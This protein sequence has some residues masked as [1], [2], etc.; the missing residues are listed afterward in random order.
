MRR[1]SSC[2][3]I[4]GVLTLGVAM[5]WTVS[6]PSAALAFLDKEIIEAAHAMANGTATA[7]QRAIAF[8]HNK[9]LNLM[10]MEGYPQMPQET[11]V[12]YQIEYQKMND[13]FIETAARRTNE[14]VVG[15]KPQPGKPEVPTPGTDTDKITTS[16]TPEKTKQFLNN[17]DEVVQEH[18][19][20]QGV[21]R[22]EGKTWAQVTDTDLMGDAWNSTPENFHKISGQQNNAYARPLAAQYE[23]VTRDV[24]TKDDVEAWKNNPQHAGKAPPFKEG[25]MKQPPTLAQHQAYAEEMKSK[26]DLMSN[27][28]AKTRQKME[29]LMKDNPGLREEYTN[30]RKAPDATKPMSDNLNRLTELDADH[31]KLNALESKY[32]KRFNDA[33]DTLAEQHGLSKPSQVS[34]LSAGGS[35]RMAVAEGDLYVDEKG[36][37]I[38]RQAVIE[39][40]GKFFD[41]K[42]NELT[43]KTPA[44]QQAELVEHRAQSHAV[45]AMDEHLTDQA[46]RRRAEVLGELAAKD[47]KVRAQALADIAEHTKDSSASLKG[48]IVENLR[49]ARKTEIVESLRQTLGEKFDPKTA[50]GI[51]QRKAD[52]FAQQAAEQMRTTATSANK[53]VVEIGFKEGFQQTVGRIQAADQA[54]GQ[55][56]GVGELTASSSAAR[57]GLNAAAEGVGGTLAVVGTAVEAYT[58]GHG[59]GTTAALLN[60]ASLAKSEADRAILLKA[61]QEQAVETGTHAAQTGALIGATIVSPI[62]AGGALTGYGAYQGTRALLEHTETGR[63]F[64]KAVRDA[65]TE[66]M[67]ALENAERRR[68]GLPST[69]R[70][71][72]DTREKREDALLRALKRGDIEYQEG[73]TPDDLFEMIKRQQKE[74]PAHIATP[75]NLGMLDSV[76]RR[77]T[78]QQ[79]EPN[80]EDQFVQQGQSSAGAAGQQVASLTPDQQQLAQ[81]FAKSALPG[82]KRITEP[83]EMLGGSTTEA[84]D[85]AVAAKQTRQEQ[86]TLNQSLTQARRQ[87]E[88]EWA[89]RWQQ[90]QQ[91]IEQVRLA[92][93]QLVAQKLAGQQQQGQQAI[94]NVQQGVEAIQKAQQEFTRQV[95]ET[96]ARIDEQKRI[97]D[98][99]INAALQAQI[100]Q[101][102]GAATGGSAAQPGGGMA[103]PGG[104]TAINQCAYNL[105]WNGPAMTIAC[106][107]QGHTFNGSKG[108]CE[109]QGGGGVVA[110]GQGGGTGGPGQVPPLIDARTVMCDAATKSGADAPASITVQV[111]SNSGVVKF[112]YNTYSVKDEITVL[113]GGQVVYDTGCVGD[114]KSVDLQVPGGSSQMTVNVRPSCAGEKGTNWD[115][116]LSCP[117]SPVVQGPPGAPGAPSRPGGVNTSPGRR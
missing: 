83:K 15:Q 67:V 29:S 19:Q 97:L 53:P 62:A 37:P 71:E 35:K 45:Q 114:T 105:T 104:T 112:R 103:G 9:Q 24:Y 55:A 12:K 51:A 40:D 16:T 65:M 63:Q 27:E 1:M 81:E 43:R 92:Q 82:Q 78:Q 44:Q 70:Q 17:Y 79:P 13:P 42:G 47:P 52:Q 75:D 108:I 101:S 93:E 99:E 36:T 7:E 58:I 30:F 77:K 25:Q 57:R 33:T 87:E 109:A 85:V 66:T 8:A 10:A 23:A 21:S 31:H 91:Q 14:K 6:P 22:P 56:L 64:D 41:R 106:G 95:A 38:E 113:Y 32:V 59:V 4:A 116:S 5:A 111:G 90:I 34:K 69:S 54:V 18:M 96:Q 117:T 98:R 20:K 3:E 49:Q 115:F 39:K 102:L 72:M 61:A 60:E 28:S 89:Q 88:A 86:D 84:E 94:Q 46:V 107:C 74:E 48:E 100:A 26:I 80:L 76:L 110:G 2:S 50:D 73:A 11:Y 68:Q